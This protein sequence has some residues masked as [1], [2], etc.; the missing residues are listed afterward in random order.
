MG[1]EKVLL[2][3]NNCRKELNFMYKVDVIKRD[4]E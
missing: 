1:I 3:I 4:V 2:R